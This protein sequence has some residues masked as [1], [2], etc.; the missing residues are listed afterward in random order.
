MSLSTP[1][2]ERGQNRVFSDFTTRL[3]FPA[4]FLGDE[5]WAGLGR[6]DRDSHLLCWAFKRHDSPVY[7]IHRCIS[8]AFT[9]GSRLFLPSL[10][11][12]FVFYNFLVQLRWNLEATHDTCN[13]LKSW[14][15]RVRIDR[16]I[17]VKCLSHFCLL[18]L[19]S[20]LCILCILQV[21]GYFPVRA[22]V[23]RLWYIFST[24]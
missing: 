3:S 21:L 2:H 11:G 19:V 8:L 20:V 24:S 17:V 14:W 13:T 7:V 4:I 23:C 10:S 9:S 15:H 16:S 1:T 22:R 5:W 6:R 18:E 12:R